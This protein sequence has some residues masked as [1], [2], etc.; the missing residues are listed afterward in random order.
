MFRHVHLHFSFIFRENGEAVVTSNHSL[1]YTFYH[2]LVHEISRQFR[3]VSVDRSVKA[4]AGTIKLV[5]RENTLFST[6]L[7]N[8]FYTKTRECFIRQFHRKHPV[9]NILLHI[10]RYFRSSETIL[11]LRNTGNFYQI[12]GIFSFF[13]FFQF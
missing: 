4:W 5:V 1:R 7:C 12:Y 11:S 10:A 6:C 13:Q 2:L 8:T 9:N 3:K